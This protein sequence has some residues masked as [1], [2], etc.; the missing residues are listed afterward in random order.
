[1][2]SRS[3]TDLLPLAR[4]LRQHFALDWYGIHGAAHWTRVR[5]HGL[6]LAR[7]SGA[8]ADVVT[9]F[10]FLHDAERRDDGTDRGHGARG[11]RLARRLHGEHFRLD[12]EGL[13][14][15]CH[16]IEF[17]SA[18][19]VEGDI[20]VRTCWDADRLDLARLGIRPDPRRLSTAAARHPEA[21]ARAERMARAGWGGRT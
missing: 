18:G 4:F 16:A 2:R 21:I 13:D 5:Y 9:L 15:L 12:A 1:M 20:T 7:Q 14:M 19:L 17:H 3:A 11:A 10:A 6:R 8:R